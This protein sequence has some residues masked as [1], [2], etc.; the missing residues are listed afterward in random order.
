M[1]LAYVQSSSG[2][3]SGS[4]FTINIPGTTLG[5]LI[6]LMIVTAPDTGGPT[7]SSIVDTFTN[8]Y[9]LIDSNHDNASFGGK[10]Y[11]YACYQNAGSGGNNVT[12]NLSGASTFLLIGYE[13]ITGQ[14]TTAPIS[15]FGA[16]QYVSSGTSPSINPVTTT[17]LSQMVLGFGYQGSNSASTPGSGYTVRAGFANSF[18]T[19]DQL[20]FG[21]GTFTPTATNSSEKWFVGSLAIKPAGA[22]PPS[23]GAGTIVF[24]IT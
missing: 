24:V 2:F 19:E 10:I 21:T 4:S 3:S 1:S 15:A 12:V 7:I 18:F 22:V 23:S 13:E 5:S 8:T 14:D 16:Y 6:L 9:H 17:F 11:T 20:F